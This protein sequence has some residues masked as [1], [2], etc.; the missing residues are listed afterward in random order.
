MIGQLSKK[1]DLLTDLIYLRKG[2]GLAAGRLSGASTLLEVCGG[3]GRPLEVTQARFVS[4]IESLP[5]LKSREVLLAA[6]G[7]SPVTSGL[8]SLGER[9]DAYGAQVDRGRDTLADWE[10]AALNELA[11]TL[12]TSYYAGA[13]L[14]AQ[15]PMPHG[16]YLL[17]YVNVTTLYRDRRFVEHEQGRRVISLVEGAAGF[18]Y[19][20]GE[21]T[22]VTALDGCTVETRYVPG[23]SVHTLRFPGLKR[24]DVHDFSFRE[25]LDGS[26][27]QADVPA[28]DLAGQSFE[29]PTLVYRQEV[30]FLGQRPSVV[31][32]YDKLSRIERPGN[33][34]TQRVLGF[35]NSATVRAEFTQLYG[36][37]FCGIAWRWEKDESVE[38]ERLE[39]LSATE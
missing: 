39:Q 17:D 22:H 33:P 32:A 21:H 30:T 27:T 20:S 7:V 36:G 15:L 11:I 5:D 6:Y 26:E 13:P 18:A 34:E 14:P 38:P 1:A 37:L 31:W 10:D 9:R 23:G 35:E 16:G 2:L 4:A 12:L 19:H 29:T 25:T 8:P 28:Q 24:G 3:R